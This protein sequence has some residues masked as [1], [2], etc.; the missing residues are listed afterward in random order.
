MWTNTQ[1][2]ALQARAQRV[3]PGGMY[4]HESTRLLPADFPQFFQRAQGTRLWDVDGNEYIDYM[5]AFGPNLLG[6]GHEAVE[7][8]ARAQAQRG[9]TMTG[10]SD[11]MVRLAELFVDTV[12]HADWAMFCKNG[13]D[14]TAMA[15]VC[16][17]AHRQRRKVLLAQGAYHG[18]APWCMPQAAGSTPEDRAHI[19]PFRYN[20]L[21]SLAAAVELAGDDLA[22]IFATPFRHEAFSDQYLPGADYARAVRRVCDERDALLVVDDVRAG[23][24]MA[25]DCSWSALGVQPDLSTWGKCIANGHPISAMLGSE[26]ARDAAKSIYVT[27]SFWFSA[28][29]MEAA[30]ATLQLVRDTD[31]LERIMHTG[32]LLRDGLQAQAASHGFALRQT[33]P[34]QMPQ[35]FFEDDADMRV[36]YAWTAAAVRRGVYL[37]PYHNMF[38]NAALTPEDVARTLERTDDAFAELRHSRAALPPQND[39]RVMERLRR[40]ALATEPA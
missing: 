6:Y 33:G 5:C 7:A 34:V 23:F 35:I 3:M 31:Y 37:H 1:D 25:R 4:G 12:S 8:A 2:K 14:A 29:P 9:D 10:P 39:A 40:A 38:I 19:I 15:L 36:G 20:D 26:K 28:V 22:G 21:D 27:G 13:T 18:A 17:R 11:A 30:I 32:Q 24:R 16:A